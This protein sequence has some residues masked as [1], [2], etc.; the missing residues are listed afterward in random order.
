MV[1][2]N[3]AAGCGSGLESWDFPAVGLKVADINIGA[4]VDIVALGL[5]QLLRSGGEA[6]ATGAGE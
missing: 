4:L 2:E 1:Q 5:H 3:R 6:C